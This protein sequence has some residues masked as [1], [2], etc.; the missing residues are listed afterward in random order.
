MSKVALAAEAPYSDA[1]LLLA[2]RLYYVDGILQ[3]QIGKM[4]GVS[5]AKVSR[6][7]A[8]ARE[9]GLVRITVPEF[10]PRDAKLE[11][12]LC[13]RL[14]L[15]AAIV[16][17]QIAG[18]SPAELRNTL[19][20][21]AGPIAAAWFSG[22]PVVAVA[23]GRSLQCLAES[24]S[25]QPGPTRAAIVQAMGHVDAAPGPYDASE[26]GRTLAQRWR[27]SFMALST[28]AFVPD[29]AVCRR[30]VELRE[31]R[32]AFDRLA[33]ADVALVGVGNLDESVFIERCV[34][35]RRDVEALRRAGAVGEILGRFY[36]AAGKECATPYRERVI[37]LPLEGLRRIKFTVGVVAGGQ[38]TE[39]IRT[40]VRGGLLKALVIDDQAAGKLLEAGGP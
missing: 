2:A 19:G 30:L 12:Q 4:V 11:Q 31:V 32:A 36:N 15:E 34:L 9:R 21:F 33:A 37:S 28:P 8:A 38:R 39:A 35:Q 20:Y 10:E 16:I 14:G 5:Q 29:A 6:M 23:G 26:I 18:Q 40:A 1:Q 27:G 24:L 7:L 25:R 17:R 3:T 22:A 13:R